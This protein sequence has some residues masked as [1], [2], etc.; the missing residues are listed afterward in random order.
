MPGI[1]N[2]QTRK[3]PRYNLPFHYRNI[4]SGQMGR[5][6]PIQCDE[7]NAGEKWKQDI[8]FVMRMTPMI[9]PAMTELDVHFYSF[10]V[11]TRV[12][13]PRNSTQSTWE[14]MIEAINKPSI[15][16]PTLP[17]MYSAQRFKMDEEK[18]KY[19]K[20]KFGIG[21]LSD[22][23]DTLCFTDE[24]INNA[25]TFYLPFDHRISLNG[26]LCYQYIYNWWFRR[27]QIEPEIT[28]PLS[29][30]ALD[31]TNV[32]N[33]DFEPNEEWHDAQSEW[34]N[35]VDNLFKLRYKNYERDYFTSAL[36]K[37]QY[38]DDVQIGG[39][40][41]NF[42]FDAAGN[43]LPPITHFSLFGEGSSQDYPLY[44]Q[45]LNGKVVTDVSSTWNMVA[46]RNSSNEVLTEINLQATPF[47]IN[48]LR[49]AMQMQSVCETI[50][51]GGTRYVEIMENVY[52]SIVPD[53]RLQQP[54]F[55]GGT[56]VPI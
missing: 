36:P 50:N 45:S 30:G 26:Y 4:L 32:D 23:L 37:P 48:E 14:K 2:I 54:V 20:D 44:Q 53:A 8:H 47:T 33:S 12:I 16:Q 46:P 28:F 35:F 39:G 19:I 22:Y 41:I 56:T 49:L 25:S 11:P 51:R 15:E 27:D 13:T 6:I 9:H 21:T 52:G 10:F 55:L 31:L 17:S 3:F 24:E 5:L 42:M 18:R 7:V 29:L 34:Y 1:N 43:L 40:H 38:G